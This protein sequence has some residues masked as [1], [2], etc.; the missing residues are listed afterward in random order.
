MF[1]ISFLN[2]VVEAL[3]QALKLNLCTLF[4]NIVNIVMIHNTTATT[5]QNMSSGDSDP[6][7]HKP[8]CAATEAS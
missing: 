2:S 1:R 6:A 8:A 7:R 5:W 4:E 3:Q